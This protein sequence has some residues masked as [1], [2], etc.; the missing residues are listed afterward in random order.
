MTGR[1]KCS[2]M[3]AGAV[4][5]RGAGAGPVTGLGVSILVRTRRLPE[6]PH[7]GSPDGRA[8][9]AGASAR[10]PCQQWLQRMPAPAGGRWDCGAYDRRPCRPGAAAGLNRWRSTEQDFTTTGNHDDADPRRWFGIEVNLTAATP[11]PADDT[12]DTPP[13]TTP[14][15]LASIAMCPY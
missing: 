11:A 8:P 7:G 15:E 14:G 13:G 6:A 2:H 4:A 12:S 5:P 1:I 10:R 3:H 9:V